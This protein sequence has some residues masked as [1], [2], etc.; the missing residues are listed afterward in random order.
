M[1]RLCVFAVLMVCASTAHAG[2]SYSFKLGSHRVYIEKSRH[3]RLHTCIS[4]SKGTRSLDWGRKR[5]EDGRDAA[6][7]PKP[8]PAAP[9][10]VAPPPPPAPPA[11][12]ASTSPA[13]IIVLA[14]PPAVQT[15]AVTRSIAEPPA[16]PVETPVAQQAAVPAPQ[17]LET[18]G[19]VRSSA[20][21]EPVMNQPVEVSP[22]SPIGDWQTEA[23]GTVRIAR[24]GD[25]LCGHAINSANEK[26]EAILINMKPKTT[27]QWSG[28][29][30]SQGSGDT[31]YG[32]MAMKGTETLRVEACA[33]YHFYCSGNN[34]S[35]VS[36]RADSPATAGPRS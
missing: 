17:S 32:T 30:Y 24:C 16:P 2:G 9:Q 21:A 35:R 5:I 33:L 11:P 27:R 7:A 18:V 23:R 26:G 25:A 29:V 22:D 8:V 4:V 20:R 19:S 3:C 10:V 12:P 36:R 14:P 28:S 6:T 31:Y 13:K 1:K 15:A 34:W